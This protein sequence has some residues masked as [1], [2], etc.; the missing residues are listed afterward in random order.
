MPISNSCLR[1]RCSLTYYTQ[2]QLKKEILHKL[3]WKVD[4]KIERGQHGFEGIKI[5]R[6]NRAPRFDVDG[7]GTARAI[8]NFIEHPPSHPPIEVIPLN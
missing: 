7:P 5:K 4:W 2:Q 3:G 8:R 6:P 1:Q